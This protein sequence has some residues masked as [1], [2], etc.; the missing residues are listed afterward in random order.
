M[1]VALVYVPS[2]GSEALVP[3]AKAMAKSLESAGHYVDLSEARADETPRLTGYDYIVVGTESAG[4]LGK[5]PGRVAKFLA[6]A[7]MLSGK[8]S[9]AFFR[10]SGLM[11]EKALGKLMK[12]MEAEGMLV[13]CAEIVVN[14]ASAAQAAREAPVERR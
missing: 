6:Q 14:E 4:A 8:R 13:N 2:K 1:R 12:A 5:I 11:P 10:K 3:I 7:G 9:M